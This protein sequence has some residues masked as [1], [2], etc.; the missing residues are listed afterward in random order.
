MSY[1]SFQNQFAM[2]CPRCKGSGRVDVQA[3]VYLRLVQDG[4]DADLSQNGDHEWSAESA[5]SCTCGFHGTV[6]DFSTSQCRNCLEIWNIGET[7]SGITKND[8]RAAEKDA[9]NN[10][11]CP[12]CGDLCRQLQDSEDISSGEDERVA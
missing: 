4:T 12:E 7:M 2:R 10:G 8:P 9:E 3:L 6:Y 11:K 1:P 5:A